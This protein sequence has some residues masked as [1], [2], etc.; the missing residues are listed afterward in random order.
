[1][2]RPFMP[3]WRASRPARV[4]YRLE[5]VQLMSHDTVRWGILGTGGIARLFANDLVLHGFALDAV[6]SRHQQTADAFAMDFEIARSHASYRELVDDPEIDVIYIATPHPFHAENAIAAL[7]AGKHVLV[8]KPFTLNATE[9]RQV[10]NLAAERGL[11]VLEAMWTR[12]LPHMRRIIE[13]LE[14]DTIG[15]VRG[16]IADHTQH[17]PDDPAHRLNALELGGGALLDLGVYP[18]SFAS[19]LFGTP[20]QISASATFKPTG[21][22]AQVATIFRY[23][24]S[25]LATTLSASNTTGPNRA[26]ILGSAGRIDIDGVW[27][28]PTSFRVYDDAGE[29]LETY[30]STVTGRGMQFQ[31]LEVERLV[32]S[33]RTASEILS[34]DE[35]VRVMETLDEIR[36]QI[37][38]RYPQE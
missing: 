25:Q 14:T 20:Q 11:L 15:E 2:A 38:L 33:G 3:H 32:T 24:D 8:E 10:V 22:D 7:N 27:Y 28:A 31:A 19:Q 9:A 12:F 17:L 36:R 37:G 30:E 18:I 6:G 34:P 21:A 26:T 16:L 1:M 23:G 35:T 5:V 13:I 4:R 29:V